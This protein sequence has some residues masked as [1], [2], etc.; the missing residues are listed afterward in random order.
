MLS[1]LLSGM[2]QRIEFYLIFVV[3]QILLKTR[4][5]KVSPREIAEKIVKSIPANECIEKVEI[6]G[7]GKIVPFYTLCISQSKR[8]SYILREK[9]SSTVLCFK[10]TV[11]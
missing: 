4:E 5:Q 9:L 1:V 3:F 6:A 8:G 7:P 10:T 11:L 2:L